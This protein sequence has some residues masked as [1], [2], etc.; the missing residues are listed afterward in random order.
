METLIIDNYLLQKKNSSMTDVSFKLQQ[1]V[2][3]CGR[4]VMHHEH[5]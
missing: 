2:D 5:K 4:N 3:N 1:E